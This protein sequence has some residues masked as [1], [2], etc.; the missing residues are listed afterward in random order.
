MADVITK[1]EH[2]KAVLGAMKG[3]LAA[4]SGGVDSSLVLKVAVDVLGDRVLAVT[5]QSATTARHESADAQALAEAL[6]V[7]YLTIQSHELELTDFVR[8]PTDRCY[9]CKKSRFTDLVKRAEDRGLEFVIDGEN[10]DDHLD[11]RPG[12]RAARELGVRS[13]LREVGLSKEE[14]RYL[15]KMLG[16]PTWN[17]PAYACLATRIP[18]HS[19]VTFEKLQQVDQAEDFIR[20]LFPGSQV[21]VR[22]HGDLARVEVD[23]D[24]IS[25]IAASEP[26][27][28]IADYLKQSGF[29][30]VCLDLEG[31]AVGSLN[32]VISVDSPHGS[33]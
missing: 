4:F 28:V 30:Y 24:L 3:V 11:Y 33:R 8:N 17:K 12:S 16:L 29:L 32:R 2:L 5:A 13:P 27:R 31:Y 25:R 19:P 18:Y 22:H 7:E 9:V 15:S 14:V 23:P 6:G 1:Y 10:A 26:R 20:G 21:R